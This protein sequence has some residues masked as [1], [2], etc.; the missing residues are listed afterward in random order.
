MFRNDSEKI[1]SDVIEKV[2][3]VHFITKERVKIWMRD[4]K[5]YV[6]EFSGFK[7]FNDELKDILDGKKENYYIS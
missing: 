5:I 7:G 2:E 3:K 1:F 4:K 6:V